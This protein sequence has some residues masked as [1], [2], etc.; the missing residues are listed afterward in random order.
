MAV[1]IPIDIS[2]SQVAQLKTIN[3]KTLQNNSSEE[4]TKLLSAAKQDGVFY[5]DLTDNGEEAH[6]YD[7]VDDIYRLSQSIFDMSDEEKLRFDVDKLGQ[8]KLNGFVITAFLN[9][10]SH[11]VFFSSRN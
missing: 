11:L 9:F 7:S 8:F 1:D 5:L 2:P 6:I 4:F 3:F 10:R